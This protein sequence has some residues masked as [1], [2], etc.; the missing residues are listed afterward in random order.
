M[1]LVSLDKPFVARLRRPTADAA[2]VK[3]AAAMDWRMMR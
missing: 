1:A 2:S 3:P